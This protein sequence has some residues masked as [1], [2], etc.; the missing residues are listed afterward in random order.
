VSTVVLDEPLEHQVDLVSSPRRKKVGRCGRRWGKT[1]L[2]F[3][4]AIVGH[5]PEGR[6]KRVVRGRVVDAWD[7]PMHRG[8]TAGFTVVWLA[9]DIP[10]AETLWTN[11]ILPRFSDNAAVSLNA[12]KHWVI[13]P[14]GG[15]LWIRSNENVES[16]RGEG[17]RLIGVVV[18]E[19]AWLDLEHAL[20]AVLNPMLLDN[21]AWL[22]LA[23]TTNAG[24]DGNAEK[25]L[26]SYFNVICEE[27]RDGLRDPD[28]WEAFHGTAFDNP[29]LEPAEI[30]KMIRDEYTAGSLDLKQEVFAELLRHGSGAAFP[31]WTEDVHVT[32]DQPPRG[33]EDWIW[34]GGGDWGSTA[35]GGLWVVATGEERKIVSLEYYFNGPLARPPLGP[36][37]VGYYFGLMIR[38]GRWP[39]PEWMA[40][41]TPTVAIPGVSILERIERGYR[42]ALGKRATTVWVNPPKGPGSRATK[43]QLLHD[44]LRFQ[45]GPDG[46]V[47][48][49]E[50]PSLQVHRS[51]VNLIRTIP[52]LS[53]NPKKSEDVDS[54]QEDHP[55]DGLTAWLM[56]RAPE[57]EVERKP[58]K[59]L[60][61]APSWLKIVG[62]EKGGERPGRR[63]GERPERRWTPR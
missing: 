58:E 54:S 16:I 12:T 60:N 33:S 39:V 61:K 59:P 34:T 19:A 3:Y 31:E 55:Y 2:I 6:H 47:S 9:R 45:R 18:D 20:K 40:V 4:C 52:L 28:E 22:L 7:G 37:K 42:K 21:G 10:Q 5:G 23:S 53:V 17:K 8:I 27:I 51:C 13:F 15:K 14:G 26:P 48:P 50:R 36:T 30:E 46:K 32:N 25:R 63:S 41:D 49:W 43:K 62:K 29:V 11:E 38:D 56:N 44:E 57:V 24:Q 35:P 1:A